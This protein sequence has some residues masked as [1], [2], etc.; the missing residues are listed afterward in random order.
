MYAYQDKP[1]PV[2]D[3][4]HAQKTFFLDIWTNCVKA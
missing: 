2:A 1:K 3:K 4:K